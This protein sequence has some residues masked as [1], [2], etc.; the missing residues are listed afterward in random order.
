MSA[1]KT[2][3]GTLHHPEHN[4]ICQF[5]LLYLMFNYTHTQT[6]RGGEKKKK[7]KTGE[8]EAQLHPFLFIFYLNA[9]RKCANL[10]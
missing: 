8:R 5:D 6:H 7:K 2:V 10:S 1:S 3:A 4:T 9:L